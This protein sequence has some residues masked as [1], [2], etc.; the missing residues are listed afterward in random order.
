MKCKDSGV[1]QVR[2]GVQQV[3]IIGFRDALKKTA[4]SGLAGQE[5]VVDF[6]MATLEPDNYFPERMKELYRTALWRE[7]LRYTGRDFSRYYSNITVM[8]RGEE[9]EKRERFVDTLTSV[10]KKLE[11][12]PIV[13][14]DAPSADGPN[15]Q[16]IINDQTVVQGFHGQRQLE[17]AI[18]KTISGW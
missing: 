17:A 12:T 1:D 14:Y 6:L 18:H 10:L 13:T 7:Y 8:V 16:L 3:G 2:V 4:E 9:G 5:E 11:L 15:P